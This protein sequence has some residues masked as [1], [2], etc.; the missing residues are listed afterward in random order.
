LAS[1]HT[2]VA[3]APS[4]MAPSDQQPETALSSLDFGTPLISD[5]SAEEVSSG[6]APPSAVCDACFL[7]EAAMALLA[8]LGGAI[9]PLAKEEPSAIRDSGFALIG[10]F[11]VLGSCWLDRA[12]EA[13][14]DARRKLSPVLWE[15]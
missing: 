6:A 13:D 9:V 4:V 10:I 8:E 12:A 15:S 2:E 11:T 1:D 7:D 14:A 5:P 3:P